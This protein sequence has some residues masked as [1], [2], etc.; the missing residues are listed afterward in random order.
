MFDVEGTGFI[1]QDEFCHITIQL[2][3]KNYNRVLRE[4]ASLIFTR[5]QQEF[6]S[7]MTY[8]EFCNIFLPSDP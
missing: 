6:P 7:K 2:T 4:Q 8:R 1:F 3:Q 5:Y